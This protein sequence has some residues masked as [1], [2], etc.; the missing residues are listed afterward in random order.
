LKE[1]DLDYN[2]KEN[3]EYGLEEDDEESFDAND[4]SD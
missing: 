1:D 4:M 3:N 2:S